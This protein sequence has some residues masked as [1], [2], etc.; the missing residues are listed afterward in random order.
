[1]QQDSY[2]K[3]LAAF[4]KGYKVIVKEVEAKKKEL[5]EDYMSSLLTKKQT[6]RELGG[7][8]TQKLDRMRKNGLIES[9]RVGG[10]VM[11]KIE[12]IA[13]YLVQG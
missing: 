7:I 10:T 11:F 4:L 5:K 9:K 2:A 12:E 1:M 8:S 6:A 13:R 3:F